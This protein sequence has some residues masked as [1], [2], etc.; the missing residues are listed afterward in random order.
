MKKKLNLND[1]KVKSFVTDL[2]NSSTETVKGGGMARVNNDRVQVT[3][4]DNCI[5]QAE[6]PSGIICPITDHEFACAR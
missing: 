5:T 4:A 3:K 6:C 2:E 1:L